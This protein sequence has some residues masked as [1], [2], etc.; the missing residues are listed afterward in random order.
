MIDPSD[1]RQIALALTRL[2]DNVLI[3]AE[4]VET[5]GKAT[6]GK[7][8]EILQEVKHVNY[9]IEPPN[10]RHIDPTSRVAYPPR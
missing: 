3:L 6:G 9:Q 4:A 8:D 7:L 5:A 2:A 1:M 10:D